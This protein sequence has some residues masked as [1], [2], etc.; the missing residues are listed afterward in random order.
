MKG[1]P[2]MPYVGKT[3]PSPEEL[4]STKV[5]G[6][7]ERGGFGRVRGVGELEK[8]KRVKKKRREFPAAKLIAPGLAAKEWE[9][10]RPKMEVVPKGKPK[11]KGKPT[12]K[13][14]PKLEKRTAQAPKVK[15]GV[16]ETQRRTAKMAQLQIPGL[17]TRQRLKQRVVPTTEIKPITPVP[18]T[19]TGF[20]FGIPK[21][22]PKAMK[23]K[24]KKTFRDLFYSEKAH[25]VAGSKEVLFGGGKKPKKRKK[26]KGKRRKKR[27]KEPFNLGDIFGF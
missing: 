16:E 21:G 10:L 27:K 11:E 7:K 19:P 25:P 24:P 8:S 12:G 18:P 14:K 2:A 26:K 4:Y 9:R 23:G 13:L 15:F 1:S 3:A 5:V 22:R 6:I 20:G 17:K